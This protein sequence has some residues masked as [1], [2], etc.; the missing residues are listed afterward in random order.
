MKL[1]YYQ[2]DGVT[3]IFNYFIEGGEGNPVVVMP[4]GTGKS[5]V[6]AKFLEIALTHYPGQR[7]MM[8]THVKELIEQNYEKLGAIWPQ[9]PAGIYSAG[10]GKKEH[11]LPITFAGIGS[12]AKN[13]FLFGHIDVILIDECHLVSPKSTTMYR[14]FIDQL[15][16]VNPNLKV[17]GFTAT[18]Y[19]LGQGTII[20][21]GLFTDICY[22]LSSMDSFNRLIAEGYLSPLTTKRTIQQINVDGVKTR[23]G[24]FIEK[25]LQLA[26]DKEEITYGALMEC[27]EHGHDR[28]KWLIFATGVDHA[29]NISAMLDTF[30]ISNVCIHG[31]LKGAERDKRLAE[32]KFGDVQVAVNNN[33]LTT[34]FDCV[35]IDLIAVLR[36]SQSPGLWVQILGRGTRP[37]FAEGFDLTTIEGRLESMAASQKQNCLILDFA[38][39]TKRLGPINDPVLPKKKGKGGGVAPVRECPAC[40]TLMHTSVRVCETCD[41]EFP[42]SVNFAQIAG[43]DE[44]MASDQPITEVFAV[45]KAFYSRNEGKDGRLPTLRVQYACGIRTFTE[46]VCFEHPEKSFPKKRARDWWRNHNGD[47]KMIPDNVDAALTMADRLSTPSHLRVWTNK[48]Y[49]EIMAYDYTGTAFNV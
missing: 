36:P 35:E 20:E 11:N 30:E 41:Y 1:R 22:D 26:C 43:T 18:P 12:V 6:I 16:I 29:I 23:G 15:L 46:A 24:D 39:N 48:K 8:L 17:V 7:M 45:D 5:L 40:R 47:H 44:V 9:A 27:M 14:K 2:D 37:C 13:A 4:T 49:P 32:F 10:L 42:E 28:K 19:R 38:G 3:S 33:V 21:D 31:K 34:G 25:D